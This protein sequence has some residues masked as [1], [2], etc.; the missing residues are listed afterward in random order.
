V[1]PPPRENDAA[2]AEDNNVTQFTSTI[3][4]LPGR[5]DPL[6]LIRIALEGSGAT[7]VGRLL[8]H[9]PHLGEKP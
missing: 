2:Q 9:W 6:E 8:E 5:V 4:T 7:G 3:V 1:K